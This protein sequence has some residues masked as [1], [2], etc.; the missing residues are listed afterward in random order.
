MAWMCP[1]CKGK[2]GHT[3]ALCPEIKYPEPEPKKPDLDLLQS[4]VVELAKDLLVL[5][6]Q[7]LLDAMDRK[8][9]PLRF[10]DAVKTERF[11]DLVVALKGARHASEHFRHAHLAAEKAGVRATMERQLQERMA[12]IDAMTPA[13]EPRGVS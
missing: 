6:I 8:E 1:T 4:R 5:D 13:E 11:R 10:S 7:A 2:A 3:T 9:N 12:E